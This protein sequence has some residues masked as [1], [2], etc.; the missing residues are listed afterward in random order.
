MAI[1][2]TT[3]AGV[4]T[5]M[6]GIAVALYKEARNRRWDLEDRAEQRRVLAEANK[7]L[8]D[9]ITESNKLS[10]DALKAANG[11]NQKLIELKELFN[12]VERDVRNSTRTTDATLALV[13]EDLHVPLTRV[14]DTTQEIKD[15]VTH[16]ERK[17][18]AKDGP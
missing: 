8:T 9:Q 11:F 5:T 17:I 15:R 16:I 13:T 12:T 1:L 14:D 6:I 3:L 4:V 10:A 7:Q 18:D 2:Y